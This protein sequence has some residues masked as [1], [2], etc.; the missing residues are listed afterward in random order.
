MKIR[1]GKRMTYNNKY[2]KLAQEVKSL[3]EK[4]FGQFSIEDFLKVTKLLGAN[5]H[6]IKSDFDEFYKNLSDDE[7]R[8]VDFMMHL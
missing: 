8:L 6:E 4:E 2:E 7:R 3:F 1:K 5:L